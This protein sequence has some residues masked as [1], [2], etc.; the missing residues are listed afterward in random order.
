MCPDRY[1]TALTDSEEEEASEGQ[2]WDKKQP[3]DELSV[4]LEEI[5]RLHE[6]TESDKRE[7]LSI[8]LKQRVEVC[9]LAVS[10]STAEYQTICPDAFVHSTSLD[11]TPGFCGG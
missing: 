4:L 2:Q 9:V 10:S 11:R 3:R 1:M 7:S 5:D 6:G 8:L